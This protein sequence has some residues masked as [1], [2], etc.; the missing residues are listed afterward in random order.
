MLWKEK[1]KVNTVAYQKPFFVKTL[2]DR[3]TRGYFLKTQHS[4]T[5]KQHNHYT[6][7]QFTIVLQIQSLVL[8]R[9]CYAATLLT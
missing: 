2:C 8:R 3:I 1:R 4:S 5:L 7:N 9:R 6:T